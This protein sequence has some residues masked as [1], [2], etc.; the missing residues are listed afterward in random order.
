[1]PTQKAGGKA[2][3]TPA[4]TQGGKAP[5]TSAKAP[6]KTRGG[7]A[8]VT[9]AK[10]PA[11]TTQK[12]GGNPKKPVTKATQGG[13]VATPMKTKT[14]KEE[15]MRLYDETKKRS[16]RNEYLIKVLLR[17]FYN[18][19]EYFKGDIKEGLTDLGE[20]SILSDADLSMFDDVMNGNLRAQYT[21]KDWNSIFNIYSD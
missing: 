7:K 5:T 16:L 20:T 12:V 14:V 8:P 3:A 18:K 6:A 11:K 13:T 21:D 17:N 2:P 4:K 19:I 1:M 9:S 15:G 10:A